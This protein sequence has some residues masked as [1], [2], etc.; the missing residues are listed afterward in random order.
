M[1]KNVFNTRTG[2]GIG[3]KS[4]KLDYDF[5]PSARPAAKA[6]SAAVKRDTPAMVADPSKL[7]DKTA[8]PTLPATPINVQT[9]KPRL[10]PV[11]KASCLAVMTIR[12]ER[13]Q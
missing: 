11:T 2:G 10:A 6:G 13:A 3:K 8:T 1:E 5:G 7:P 12:S 9:G 4:D